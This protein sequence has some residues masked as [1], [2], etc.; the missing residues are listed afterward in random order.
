MYRGDVP[1]DRKRE[2]AAL[3]Q[4]VDRK[5]TALEGKLK[6][7]PVEASFTDEPDGTD[8]FSPEAESEEA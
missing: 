2:M 8:A 6:P 1:E 5:L 4:S 7:P 3:W